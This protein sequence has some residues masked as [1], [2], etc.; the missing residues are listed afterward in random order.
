MQLCP[1]KLLD[2]VDSFHPR[3]ARSYAKAL[4]DVRRARKGGLLGILVPPALL[5]GSGI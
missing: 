2:D 3:E 5:R 1:F 4:V